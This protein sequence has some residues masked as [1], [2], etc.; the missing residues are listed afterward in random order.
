MTESAV[1]DLMRQA[2][3]G[4]EPQMGPVLGKAVRAARRARRQRRAASV[5]AA[6]VITV[7]L[8]VGASAVGGPGHGLQR[9]AVASAQF[10]FIEP[11]LP[12]LTY[13][14]V[15]PI[16]REYLGQLLL[17][18]LPASA[19]HSQ[20]DASANSNI[21]G[22]IGR[23]ATASF[24]EVTTPIGSGAVQAEMMAVGTTDAQFGCPT[25]PAAGSCKAYSL[26]GGVKVVEEYDSATLPVGRARVLSFRVQ[27]FRPRVAVV[28]LSES[29]KA[30]DTSVVSFGMPLTAA[31]LLAAAVDPRWQFYVTKPVSTESGSGVG[32]VM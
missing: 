12:D 13:V 11:A 19:A 2:M 5:A 28:S 17:A 23:T 6:V 16:T 9:R 26:A 22:A 14:R 3:A 10:V 31:Q 24:S 18:E 4:D 20:V 21:P 7:G 29:N 1:R 8:V 32:K 25:G 27:V 30:A 15:Q